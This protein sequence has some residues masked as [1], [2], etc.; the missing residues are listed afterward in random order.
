[1]YHGGLSGKIGC[2]EY[3]F[4]QSLDLLL[5]RAQLKKNSIII[6]FAEYL[7]ENPLTLNTRKI[8]FC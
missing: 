8:C 5:I 4:I 3:L 7:V 2:F 6:V 1:M